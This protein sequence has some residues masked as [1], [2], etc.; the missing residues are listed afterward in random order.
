[1]KAIEH[2]T[3]RGFQQHKAVGGTP[4]PS[5]TEAHTVYMRE[6]GR[7]HY[8]PEKRREAYL[9]DKDRRQTASATSE[10]R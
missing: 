4:C 5:C 9:R 2:G 10:L 6:Y 8:T 3:R 1:M 7:A